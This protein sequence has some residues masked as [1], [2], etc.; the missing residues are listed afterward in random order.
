MISKYDDIKTIEDA[1]QWLDQGGRVLQYMGE[2][3]ICYLEK[4]NKYKLV[5]DRWDG[6]ASVEYVSRDVAEFSL[7]A[8][9]PR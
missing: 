2:M 7:T 3:G 6:N 5:M 1:M 9:Y 8:K 4:E